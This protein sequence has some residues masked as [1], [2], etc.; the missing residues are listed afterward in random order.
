MWQWYLIVSILLIAGLSKIIT[1]L[2]H[3]TRTLDSILD[4]LKTPDEKNR[5]AFEGLKRE[6]KKIK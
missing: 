6:L 1:L 2:T 4:K 3:I 5:E